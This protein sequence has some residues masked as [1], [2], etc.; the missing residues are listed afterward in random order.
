MLVFIFFP[1]L[2]LE[3]GTS[4]SEYARLIYWMYYVL[5]GGASHCAQPETLLFS[6]LPDNEKSKWLAALRPQ[7]A[8]GWDDKITYTGW[9]DVPSVY[10]I[11]ESDKLLPTAVQEQLA[12]LAGSKVE[13]CS[14]GHVPQLSQ[15]ER[16]VEVIK[17]ASVSFLE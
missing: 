2:R 17:A 10:L 15:P 9:K 11:C 4:A 16:V 12:D 3:R 7:P 8:H 13:R 5:Q 14:A 6:D 1:L